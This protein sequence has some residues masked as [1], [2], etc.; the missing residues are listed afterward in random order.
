M[1]NRGRI[2]GDVDLGDG[3]DTFVFAKGGAVYGTVI[4]GGGDDIARIENGAG[5]TVIADFAAGAASGDV[6]DISEFFSSFGAVQSHSR[7]RGSDV[8]ITLDHNDTLILEDVQFSVLN[9]GDFLLV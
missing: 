3:A 2:V 7:Q 4:L 8:V 6:I 1:L 5:K 9:A